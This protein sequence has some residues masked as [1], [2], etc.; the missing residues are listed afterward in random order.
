[1]RENNRAYF[2]K[3]KLMM[4]Q[5]PVTNSSK[6]TRVA[7]LENTI[8]HV[9]ETLKRIDEHIIAIDEKL[10]NNFFNLEQKIEK[11]FT[12]MDE[13]IEKRFG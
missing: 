12:I 3:R 13:K 2:T 11:H 10:D 4:A 6:T 9:H 5:P 8:R 1:M 7:I